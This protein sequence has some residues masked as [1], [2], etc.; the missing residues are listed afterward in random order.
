MKFTINRLVSV[1]PVFLILALLSFQ[2][3]ATDLNDYAENLIVDN[4]FRGQ[5][6]S[7]SSPASY[8]VGL[9]TTSCTD[10]AL[11]TE[12]TGGSYARIGVTRAV[13]SWKGT[14]GTNSGASSG[15]DGI[16][17]ND[18]AITFAAPTANWGTITSFSISDAVSAG[19]PIV[20]TDLTTSKTVNNGDAAPSFASAALTVQIDN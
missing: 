3:V 9:H 8:Y 13:G 2:A 6:Y 5:A 15:T 17:D 1:V 20:C 4:I 19:N 16:V 7:E 11:G 18:A 10:A 12:V 14:H